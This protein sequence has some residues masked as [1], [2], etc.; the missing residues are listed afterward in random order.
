MKRWQKRLGL[1]V[2]AVLAVVLVA[3]AANTLYTVYVNV[4]LHVRG[5]EI[6]DDSL[7]VSGPAAL[8]ST[9][10][11]GSSI[12]KTDQFYAKNANDTVAWTGVTTSSFVIAFNMG[13][14]APDTV[15]GLAVKLATNQ[16]IVFRD[17]SHLEANQPY[18][19][20]K[21]R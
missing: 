15:S 20:A 14:N 12:L 4:K 5:Y 11:C 16:V 21:L 2:A 7:R 9:L 13:T 10:S 19:L 3:F 18:A 17:S 8:N 6:V 1:L